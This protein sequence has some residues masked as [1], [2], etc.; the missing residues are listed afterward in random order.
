MTIDKVPLYNPDTTDFK[1]KYDINADRNP[2]TFVAKA[3]EI[4]WHIPVI[5]QHIKNHLA[6]HLVNKRGSIKGNFELAKKKALKE[7]EVDLTK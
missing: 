6:D 2:K 3:Q 7:I 4:S 1:V 5:A